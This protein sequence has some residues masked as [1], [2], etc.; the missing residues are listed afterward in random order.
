VLYAPPISSCC[1]HLEH[2]A[3]VKSFISFQFLN[4]RQSVGLLGRGIS[5]TQGRY[6]HRTTQ[7]QNKSRQTSMP[8]VGFEPT[9]PTFE[10]AKTVHASD[11]AACSYFMYVQIFSL[12]SSSE[13]QELN[14]ALVV[15][16]PVNIGC[17]RPYRV[18]PPTQIGL[19]DNIRPGQVAPTL[20]QTLSSSPPRGY[21]TTEFKP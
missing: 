9:I 8:S 6:L 13:S 5:P 11:L 17:A 14:A 12:F 10:R 16:I 1:S 2:R 18:D 19:Q 15:V 7:R 3:S 21:A 20:L 4:L